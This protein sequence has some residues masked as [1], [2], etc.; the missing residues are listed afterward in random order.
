MRYKYLVTQKVLDQIKK[1]KFGPKVEAK[2]QNFLNSNK[3]LNNYELFVDNLLIHKDQSNGAPRFIWAREQRM[4]VCIYVLRGIY[5]HEGEYTKEINVATK[6]VWPSKHQYNEAEERQINEAFEEML[7]TEKRE[8][9]PEELRKYEGERAFDKIRDV[10]VYETEEWGKGMKNVPVDYWQTIQGGIS[11]FVSGDKKGEIEQIGNLLY[12]HIE[13]YTITFRYDETNSVSANKQNQDICLIQIVEGKEPNLKEITDKKYDRLTFKDLK[14]CSNKCYPDYYT[15]EYK[16]W[17]NVENDNDANLALSDE[18]VEILQNVKF[19][20]FVSGL[21]G[22]GKSTILHHLFANIFKYVAPNHPEQKILFLSYNTELVEKAK[23]TVKSILENNSSHYSFKDFLSDKQN[24]AKFNSCFSSFS[25]FLRTNFLDEQSLKIFSDD[26]YV[27]YEKFRELYETDNKIAGKHLSSSILWSVI[28][29]FIKGRGL[30]PFTPEDYASDEIVKNDQ[31]VELSDYKE[32]YKA[33]N[34]WYRHYFEKG[35]QWD[36]LDLVKYVLTHSNTDEIFHKYWVIFCDEAQDF[37]KLEIDLILRLSKH[38]QFNLSATEHD[39]RIPIA[40]AGDPNQTINPTGFRWAG[41]KAIFSQAFKDSLKHYPELDD[42]ELSINYRSQLGIVKFANTIQSIRYKYFDDTSK[43]RKLQ[44]V[45]SGID[46]DQKESFEY[47]GFYSFD[48]HKDIILQNISNAN[49]ITCD[50][51]AIGN[52]QKYEEIQRINDERRKDLKEDGK[53]KKEDIKLNTALGTKGLEYDGVMLY[54]FSSDPAYKIFQNILSS[55]NNSNNPFNSESEKFEIAHFFTKLYIAISRAKKQLFI[56]DTNEAYNNFWK[57]FTEHELWEKMMKRFVADPEKRKLVGHVTIGNIDDLPKRLTDTYDAEENARQEFERAK[58]EK[59][60]ERMKRAQ[61]YFLE[62][63]LP[64]RADE[65]EAYIY[66]F[67]RAYIKAGDKFLSL[68][69]DN[70]EEYAADAFWKGLCWKQLLM[71]IKPYQAESLHKIRRFTASFMGGVDNV[72]D[73]IANLATNE[74]D[75]QNAIT[76]HFDDQEIWMAVLQSV[77]QQLNNINAVNI[78]SELISHITRVSKYVKWYDKG[79]VTLR[80]KLLYRKGEFY[81]EGLSVNDAAFNKDDYSAAIDLWEANNLTFNN[82]LY[83]RAK[84]AVSKTSS[85]VIMW[86][87]KLNEND[88]IIKQYGEVHQAGYLSEEA[89]AIIFA[90]LL[91]TQYDKAI[92]YPFPKNEEQKWNRLYNKDRIKFLQEVVLKDFSQKK[93]AVI[94]ESLLLEDSTLFD[95]KSIDK[96]TFCRLFSLSKIDEQSKSPEWTLFLSLKD[97]EGRKVLYNKENNDKLL[98]ALSEV[99]TDNKDLASCFLDMLFGAN[100]NFEKAKKHLKIVCAIFASN[101]LVKRDFRN[102][103]GL[104]SYFVKYAQLSDSDVDKIKDNIRQFVVTYFKDIKNLKKAE[105]IQLAKQLLCAYELCVQYTTTG[106][107]F[108]ATADYFNR[109]K[110]LNKLASITNWLEQRILFNRFLLHGNSKVASFTELYD[111]FKKQNL[112]MDSFID[113]L[114]KDDAI[115]FVAATNSSRD[116]YSPNGTLLSAKLIYKY[117]L[118]RRDFYP[119]Q[120]ADELIP[121]ISANSKQAIGKILSRS[122]SY[123]EYALKILAYVWEA[124]NPNDEAAKYY[125]DFVSRKSLSKHHALLT[126]AKK[127]ALLHYSFGKEK[128][129]KKKQEEYGISMTRDYLPT[130]YPF[131]E[132]KKEKS[133]EVSGSFTPLRKKED[134]NVSADDNATKLAQ[135]QM[136][137]NLKYAGG[138]PKATILQCA[139][140]ITEEEFDNL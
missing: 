89:Q 7:K 6:K 26:K 32:A 138:V 53:P 43:K 35:E 106:P 49:I 131:I 134:S 42:Q 13:N 75:F 112:S 56:V 130:S 47:V 69:I 39:K 17:K 86:M 62:A 105:D 54:K 122:K 114:T 94:E 101:L 90:I 88:L 132:D 91:N 98:E 84:K 87:S 34:N 74:D 16:D 2:L 118:K 137:K 48:E 126:Y 80:A 65:C 18:E 109:I 50:E 68:N 93:L 79:L 21:A 129:F 29:T 12:F 60:K 96:E 46:A 70:K 100:Y 117:R 14:N 59:S 23:D 95:A 15:Y 45:R 8:S 102:Y 38:S 121:V 44:S 10:I 85:E 24:E 83:Y 108:R 120:K 25:N 136:A 52:E 20:F 33:W 125:D 22:S 139:P 61:S 135:L 28:R 81:N 127:R 119:K 66:L 37:T 115:E 76:S 63:G 92:I 71:V 140:L 107:D 128:Q 58:S 133:E 40:F 1:K 3:Q 9:L 110:K 77:E 111:N 64:A 30:T 124:L 19:P 31:T 57:Y 36:D 51:G 41:T 5:R 4:D 27:N 99:A 123:N 55:E 116:N 113:E 103:T 104:N 72:Q 97:A 11:E 73:F 78:S 67:Q 82:E